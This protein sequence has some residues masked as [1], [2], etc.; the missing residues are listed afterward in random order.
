MR[1]IDEELLRASKAGD[2]E[3]VKELLEKGADVNV[4]DYIY[5]RTALMM[6]LSWFFFLVV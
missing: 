2:K 6:L 1:V 5:G 3:K 4:K